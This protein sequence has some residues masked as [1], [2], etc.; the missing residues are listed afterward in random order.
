MKK[1]SEEFRHNVAGII[2]NVLET[3]DV[4]PE[5]RQISPLASPSRWNAAR[6]DHVI[7]EDI[8]TDEAEEF[9]RRNRFEGQEKG[10]FCMRVAHLSWAILQSGFRK[11]NYPRVRELVAKG[12]SLAVACRLLE[13]SR[14]I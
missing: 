6:S 12:I 13:L 4:R 11:M 3:V 7:C 9:C 10:R 14:P 2:R 1:F 5:N 8:A